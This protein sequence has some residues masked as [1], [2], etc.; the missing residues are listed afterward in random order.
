MKKRG[1][2]RQFDEAAV[3][4]A[5]LELF[6]R[7]GFAATSLDD[8]AAATGL[9][10]P[11]LYRAFGN[12]VDMYVMCLGQFAD[13]MKR[14]SEEAFER[15]GTLE[16]GLTNL[17]DRLI[18]V[19]CVHAGEGGSLG[20]LVFSTAVAEAPSHPEI[21]KA[22]ASGL[23]SVSSSLRQQIALHGAEHPQESVRMAADV[24]LST[25]LAL[26]VQVR[27]G[28]PRTEIAETVRNC[29]AAIVKLLD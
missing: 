3:I 28:R 21:Q 13:R 8:I 14:I 19:Y 12:K 22:V 6:W 11:S 16:D 5:M 1:R 29:V 24:A 7:K 2:P 15:T 23:D 17:F 26:G 18:D 9:N 4:A 20:C 10:R 25:F 27:A